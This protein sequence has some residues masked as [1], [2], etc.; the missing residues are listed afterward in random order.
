MHSSLSLSHP[1][2]QTYRQTDRHTDTHTPTLVA[3]DVWLNNQ[4]NP[5]TITWGTLREN[6][7]KLEKDCSHKGIYLMPTWRVPS[8]QLP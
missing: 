8:L 1:H 2:R 7:D 4:L 6:L 3:Q 5:N